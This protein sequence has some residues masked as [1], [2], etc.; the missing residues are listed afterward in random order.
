[1]KLP[2]GKVPTQAQMQGIDALIDLAR[3]LPLPHQAYILATAWHET[4]GR[5]MPIYEF[6]SKSYF[7]KYNAGTKIGKAL[8]NTLPGDGFK[9]R[10]RGFVQITGRANYQRLS[11]VAGCDLVADPDQALEL[12]IAAAIAVAGMTKGL[13]TG[14]GLRD[15][16]TYRDMRRAVNGMD[17]A[18]LISGFASHFQEYLQRKPVETP[19]V[20]A[21]PPQAPTPPKPPSGLWAAIV[22]LFRGVFNRA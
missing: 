7:D 19:P 11:K 14:K 12:P 5:M 21:E 13:F 4:A 1:M 6:G 9:Y 17:R 8:G 10:G 20:S 22:A 16:T 3:D 2:N 15:F 18:D